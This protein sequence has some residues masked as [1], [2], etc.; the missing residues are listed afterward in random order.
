MTGSKSDNRGR[1]REDERASGSLQQG[2]V[3]RGGGSEDEGGQRNEAEGE[4]E[5]E[6]VGICAMMIC[7]DL[8]EFRIV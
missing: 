4:G 1:V 2:K 6:G 5:G 8:Q 3:G 7:V